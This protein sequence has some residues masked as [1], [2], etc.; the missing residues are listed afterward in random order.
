MLVERS[1]NT[2]KD[3]GNDSRFT[4]SNDTSPA[5]QFLIDHKS[6]KIVVSIETH[7]ADNGFFVWSGSTTDNYRACSLL[8]VTV[9]TIICI[10]ILILIHRY[11]RI[12]AQTGYSSTYPMQRK[13]R[14]IAT[15]P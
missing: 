11:S 4:W 5:E 14:S 6:A 15:N 12:V 13:L 10:P 3:S 1:V 8:E 7:S 2:T 9:L